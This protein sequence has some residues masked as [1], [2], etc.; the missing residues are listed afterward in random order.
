MCNITWGIN[1]CM[2]IKEQ[3]VVYSNHSC[4]TPW[5]LWSLFLAWRG[6]GK[7]K[8]SNEALRLFLL[9]HFVWKIS[10]VT[11]MPRTTRQRFLQVSGAYRRPCL[12]K[13]NWAQL[14]DMTTFE[15]IE[16]KFSFVKYLLRWLTVATVASV[17]YGCFWKVQ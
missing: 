9:L 7:E 1:H 4:Q 6:N 13:T 15:C 2:I 8:K 14:T 17:D 10:R 16:V 5:S 12:E 3:T 11:G